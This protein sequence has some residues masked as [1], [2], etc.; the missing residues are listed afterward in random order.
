L[1]H[2][3]LG[4]PAVQHVQYRVEVRA[5]E[6]PVGVA[7]L[8]EVIEAIDVPGLHG[9]HGEN[10]LG[11]DIKR[12]FHRMRFLDVLFE[13]RPGHHRSIQEVTPMG[14]EDGAPAGLAHVM[15]GAADALDR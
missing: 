9:G 3:G 10:D 15:S 13:D 1:A 2:P 8:H 7:P 6:V 14:R 11:K 5:G 12:R 4:V